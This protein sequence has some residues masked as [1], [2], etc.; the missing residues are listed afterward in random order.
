MTDRPL[1]IEEAT[2]FLEVSDKTIRRMLERGMLQ[3]QE[4][5]RGR[6][7]I[8][9][10]SLNAAAEQLAHERG[11]ADQEA[12]LIL[13]SQAALLN[14]ERERHAV[15]LRAKEERINELVAEVATLKTDQKYMVSNED[16]IAYERRI[17]ELEA[18]IKVVQQQMTD[19]RE[20]PPVEP[21]SKPWWKLW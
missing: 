11:Q 15:E 1:T 13:A 17:A 6:I 12:Q 18:V 14:L 20:N 19:Q 21:Q 5:D 10:A 8:T 4:R 7:V 3:E 9:A 2:K 16:K